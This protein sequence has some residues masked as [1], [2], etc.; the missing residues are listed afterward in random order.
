M[1]LQALPRRVA[2]V[3]SSSPTCAPGGSTPAHLCLWPNLSSQAQTQLAQA[4]A[5]LLRR[6]QRVEAAERREVGHADD[7]SAR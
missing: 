4:M 1:T 5:Q 6:L 2:S 3:P 7:N